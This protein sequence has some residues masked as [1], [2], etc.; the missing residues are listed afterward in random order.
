MTPLFKKLNFKGQK[1]ILALNYP[2]SFE[3]ELLAMQGFTQIATEVNAI[4]E[5]EFTIC[6]VTTKAQIVEYAAAIMPGF[7][8]DAILWFCYPKGTSKN[9]KC[10]FNRDTGWDVLGQYNLEPVRQVAIDND[11]SA[12]RFRRVEFIKTIT[13]AASGA[14]TDEAKRRTNQKGKVK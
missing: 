10:E 14:I 7:N 1:S 2:K 13:R 3:A 4:N 12:I 5:V 11:W 9:Y 6:F 8:G